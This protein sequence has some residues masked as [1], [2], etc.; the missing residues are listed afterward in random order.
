MFKTVITWTSLEDLMGTPDLNRDRRIFL[1]AL[2]DLGKTTGVP[3]IDN[4]NFT[5]TIE[6]QDETSAQYWLDYITSLAEKYTKTIVS[7]TIETI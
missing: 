2:K 4:T 1:D 5:A 7:K 6:F 3:I